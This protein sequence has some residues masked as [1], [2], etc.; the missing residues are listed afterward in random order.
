MNG[1]ARAD[2]FTA[3]STVA[4][5]S[6]AA[7]APAKEG[8][9]TAADERYFLDVQLLVRSLECV[10]AP[11]IAVF[12]LGLRPHQRAWLVDRPN[13]S[14]LNLPTLNGNVAAPK[15]LDGWQLWLKPFYLL[16]APFDR[17][18]WLDADTVV[19]A[20]VDEAFGLIDRS[21][22]LINDRFGPATQN[23]PRLYEVLPLPN[24]VAIGS[25]GLNTGVVGVCK[26]RDAELLARWA[27]AVHWATRH[28]NN[29]HLLR[30]RDQGALIWA[31]YQTD[32]AFVVRHDVVWNYPAACDANLIASATIAQR[33]LWDEL[34]ARF[35]TA[36]ILHWYGVP[37]LSELLRQEIGESAANAIVNDELCKA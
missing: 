22:L 28:A 3:N 7:S 21:P 20:E 6:N 11:S 9:V 1:P 10:G 31:I 23:D 30:W 19:V 34:R 12:D 33:S 29:R 36:K 5:V 27:D 37:K 32:L 25:W 14:C 24:D 2:I 4:S 35:P 13:T 18:L 8:V 26:R 15:D 17:A 16:L